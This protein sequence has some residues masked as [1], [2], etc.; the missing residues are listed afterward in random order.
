MGPQSFLWHLAGVEWL[1]FLSF[2]VFPGCPFL[3]LWLVRDG[4]QLGL[5]LFYSFVFTRGHFWVAVPSLGCMKRKEHR[6]RSPLRHP[7]V[8]RSRAS[9]PSPGLQCLLTVVSQIMSRVLS[10]TWWE[11]QGKVQLLCLLGS[12]NLCFLVF[13]QARLKKEQAESN[14]ILSYNCLF[15]TYLQPRF[16]HG[17]NLRQSHS[18]LVV[19]S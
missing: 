18:F 14:F 6:E 17:W 16:S 19:F 9:S 12:G 5:F 7:S 10:S 4:F 13:E 11:E 8:R 1:F 3:V 15:Q 2:L